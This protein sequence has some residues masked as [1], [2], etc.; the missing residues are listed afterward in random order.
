MGVIRISISLLVMLCTTVY[1]TE[2]S[3][4][5]DAFSELSLET[6]EL[7]YEIWDEPSEFNSS[8]FKAY[9]SQEFTAYVDV[10]TRLSIRAIACAD[11]D[12]PAADDYRAM[13]DLKELYAGIAQVL[14][15]AETQLKLWRDLND[16]NAQAQLSKLIPELSVSYSRMLFELS[17]CSGYLY[18]E[19]VN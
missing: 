2:S 13:A 16:D 7:A 3:D 12:I 9:Y 4:L 18:G 1:A 14:T 5:L 11:G 15:K 19:L 8:A 17:S 6:P 10:A